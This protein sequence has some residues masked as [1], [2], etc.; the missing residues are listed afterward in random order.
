M[1][2]LALSFTEC[3]RFRV[4]VSTNGFMERLDT[5]SP[6]DLIEEETRTK[7]SSSSTESPERELRDCRFHFSVRI[8]M[9]SC[10]SIDWTTQPWPEQQPRASVL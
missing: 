6:L 1:P 9:G 8:V 4:F 10:T 7:T 2:D 5:L 3:K